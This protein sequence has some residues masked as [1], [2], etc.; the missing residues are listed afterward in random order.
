MT[1][2]ERIGFVIPSLS[3]GGAE[4]V[5]QRLAQ[6]LSD[7][8]D[9]HLL[10]RDDAEVHYDASG[11]QLHFLDYSKASFEQAIERL[12]LDLISDHFHWDPVHVA[13]MGKIA[14]AGTPVVLTEHNSYYYPLFSAARETA[15][16]T[17]AFFETRYAIYQKFAAV[18][19]LNADAAALF[20]QRLDNVRVIPNPLS[21]EPSGLADEASHQILNVSSFQ[22]RAKRLDLL[23]AAFAETLKAR[24]EARL[25]VVGAYDWVE[26]RYYRRLAGLGAEA[27][28]CVGRSRSVERHFKASSVFALSS[29]IE[30]QPMALLE[31]AMHG[32]PQV[33]FDL[34]GL[35]AQIIDG[36]TGFLAPIGDV[37]GFGARMAALLG[38]ATLRRRMGGA[39]RALVQERFAPDRVAERWASLFE[40]IGR[41]GRIRTAPTLNGPEAVARA[42]ALDRVWLPYWRAAAASGGGGRPKVSILVPVYD[43]EALL[44]RCLRSIQG[45]TLAAFECIIVDDGSPGDPEAAMRQAVGDDPRF[46]LIRHGRN[47]GLHQARSTAAEAASGLYFAHVD[48]DDY[49]HP[50]YAEALFEEAMTTGADI[51]ECRAIELLE[52]GTPTAFNYDYVV[53]PRPGHEAAMGFVRGRIRNV[54]WNKL[55]DAE[56]WRRDPRHSAIDVGLSLAEDTLR[57]AF[58]FRDCQTYSAVADCLYYY[59]RRGGSVVMGGGLARLA[60]KLGDLQTAYGYALAAMADG[61]DGRAHLRF[62]ERRY[63]FDLHWYADEYLGRLSGSAADAADRAAA[64]GWTATLLGSVESARTAGLNQD[65]WYLRLGPDARAELAPPTL[66]AAGPFRR[67]IDRREI[68]HA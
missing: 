34:P 27:V 5:V 57:N 48:S 67:A 31:A 7:R 39:A 33:A 37:Q 29:D 45:Q 68:G 55:Y 38:D 60:R 2:I 1:S 17:A 30:G 21:Y 47:R 26:D 43:T 32:L 36:E 64:E 56:L 40:D 46:R 50:R 3:A 20:A 11:L 13:T 42:E 62:L 12:G 6:T 19:V 18:T 52:N 15:A 14:E 58:L 65:Q 24:P 22:K 66:T 28:R 35:R 59:C 51:V 4:R 23:Y 49:V 63:F 54:V 53:G 16:R 9:C 8:F 41:A 25:S 61:P 10:L 44:P